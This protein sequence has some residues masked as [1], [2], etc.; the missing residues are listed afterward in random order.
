MKLDDIMKLK[1]AGYT[2]EEIVNLNNVLEK[3]Q[4]EQQEQQ[5][6]QE[7][8]NFTEMFATM[9][10]EIMAEMKNLFISGDNGASGGSRE[11]VDDIL[12]NALG[13]NKKE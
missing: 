10:N 12:K 6:Q 7:Q 5:E 9:K 1:E 3:E 13:L 2:A 8:P 4:A 11:T